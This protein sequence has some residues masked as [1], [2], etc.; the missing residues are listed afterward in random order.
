MSIPIDP[1]NP[2]GGDPWEGGEPPPGSLPGLGL[3]L[4][5]R[6]RSNLVISDEIKGIDLLFDVLFPAA[7]MFISQAPN[8]QIR[9]RNKKP[10]DWGLGLDEFNSSSNILDVDNVSPWITDLRY[11]L[12]IDPYTNE[13]EVRDV[14]DANYP[15]AQNSVVLTTST[16]ADLDITGFSGCDGNSTPATA[17]IEVLDFT[18]GDTYTVELDGIEI[19]FIPSAGDTLESIAGFLTGAFRGHPAINRRFRFDWETGD[20]IVNLTALFGTLEID[21]PLKKLH[22]APLPNPTAAPVLTATA[23]GNLAAGVYRVAYAERNEHGQT[24]LSPFEAVTLSANQ[25]IT[26]SA[27]TP[28]DPS[29]TIVWYTVPAEDDFKNLRYHSEN[30]GSSFVIDELP[31]LSAPFPP[32]LNRTG[33]EVMRI[34]AVFSDRPEERSHVGSSNVLKATYE[35]SLSDREETINQIN[36]L[37]REAS[38]DYKLKELRVRNDAH[39]ARVGKPKSRDING[40]AIDNLFQ[41]FR[42]AYGELA[43]KR[44]ADFFYKWGSTREAL[45]LEEFDVVAVTDNGSGVINLPVSIET[46]EYDLA[47]AGLPKAT[48][49]AR[50]FANWLYDDSVVKQAIPIVIE[51]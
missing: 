4:D 34:K 13:S 42:I 39:I 40:Q 46:K 31:L 27:I 3:F 15:V 43:E 49:V 41:A 47:S 14:I 45:L 37:Y 24:L 16:P 48:F 2:G 32:D 22:V 23:S 7:R 17:S 44:D 12:L 5:R 36:L 9:F 20:S 50:L 51:N 33:T 10:V 18:A 21:A 26:V 29:N 19:S 35:W 1:E 6:Y 25:K 8:G 30:D 28:T 38:E 11:H